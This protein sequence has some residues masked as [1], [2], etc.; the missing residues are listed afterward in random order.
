MKAH[1]VWES[2]SPKKIE[3]KPQD[4]VTPELR[5]IP[6]ALKAPK[7]SAASSVWTG[8]GTFFQISFRWK[9]QG[10]VL[11]VYS[12]FKFRKWQ[13]RRAA[14]KGTELRVQETGP[15]KDWELCQRFILLVMRWL[16]AG[17]G[18]EQD[19]VWRS[20]PTMQPGIP[21]HT[22]RKAEQLFH[23]R[24]SLKQP[25]ILPELD[26]TRQP[27]EKCVG[28]WTW[29]SP[30]HILSWIRQESTFSLFVLTANQ[31]FYHRLK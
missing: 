1:T 28:G 19:K 16:E 9:T 10:W 12:M 18:S 4:Q 25:R 14:Q 6:A 15:V 2:C 11:E 30:T 8:S 17:V 3:S 27:G 26:Q 29:W 21:R 7:S 31:I 5:D 13:V 20:N 23:G 24:K 22:T